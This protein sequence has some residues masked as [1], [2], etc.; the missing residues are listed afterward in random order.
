M[1]NHFREISMIEKEGNHVKFFPSCIEKAKGAFL[2]AAIGDALGWPYEF[3]AS[4]V[5][6]TDS[7]FGKDVQF[8]PWVRKS[9]GRYYPYDEEIK[10]GEY[11]DDTQLILA[12]ARSLLVEGKQ[13]VKHFTFVELPFWSLYERGGGGATR[14]AA[15]AWLA[16]K[17]P[18]SGALKQMDIKKYF[19]AGGNGVAMRILPHVVYQSAQREFSIIARE[20]VVNG[21]CTHGHPRALVGALAYAYAL[22]LAFREKSTLKYGELLEQLLSSVDVW[23]MLPS[24]ESE[25]PS[26]GQTAKKYIRDTYSLLW[27]ETVN[28]M[29][30]LLEIGREAMK[31]GALSVD[32]ETLERLG[33]FDKKINGAGTV[34]AGA[35]I[36]LASRYAADPL[37][38]ILEAAF[39][40]G[41]DT[42]T[43]AS[44]T[45]GL[46]GAI[47][48]TEWLDPIRRQL[49]DADYLASVAGAIAGEKR[50]D[51][52]QPANLPLFPRRIN[53]RDI[54]EILERL[55][56]CREGDIISL[57]GKVEFKV[58]KIIQP[59]TRTKNVR[60]TSWKLLW[61]GGQTIYVTKV[62][63][64]QEFSPTQEKRATLFDPVPAAVE[65]LPV[66]IVRTGIKL[67]VSDLEK[68]RR[69]YEKALGLP[70]S[71][72]SKN[73]VN[74]SGSISLVKK[75]HENEILKALSQER[76]FNISSIIHIET[77][78]LEATWENVRRFGVKILQS[79]KDNE[80]G[81]KYFRCLD[82]DGNIVEIFE[83]IKI[84]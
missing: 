43:I 6:S 83:S 20:V 57:E 49:Q 5:G 2:G 47:A 21:I 81:Q 18:W 46:L 38:G 72:E 34:T 31:Q 61:F 26:W 7:L 79:V 65:M 54:D 44:M 37:H 84:A 55:S 13:W 69:F 42:D 27:Q 71:K 75:S 22:W 23:G 51:S 78:S 67:P 10:A 14:R 11:S 74:L 1:R 63:R 17:E 41:A 30:K 9:G 36:F 59:Q 64:L 48:G 60:A 82:P 77:S 80:H 35:A 12:T 24:V 76:R 16:G 40:Q 58:L 50:D 33:C 73:F 25:F 8:H 4:R 56:K 70:V 39:S 28:E 68:S 66:T 53:K 62:S 52:L 32:R 29:V 45:G 3:R 15:E 19:D